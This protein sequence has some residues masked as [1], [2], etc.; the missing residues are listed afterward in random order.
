MR[1]VMAR[2][3]IFG[4]CPSL[5]VG[6]GQRTRTDCCRVSQLNNGQDRGDEN[7][8]EQGAAY[9]NGHFVIPN[10]GVHIYLDCK[11]LAS[12]PKCKRVRAIS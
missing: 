10:A 2:V 6:R 5:F 11:N 1:H 7:D 12:V 9:G 3:L 4:N 8:E